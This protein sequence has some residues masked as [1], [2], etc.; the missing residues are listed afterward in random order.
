MNLAKV[1]QHESIYECAS[2][3]K[4]DLRYIVE[5]T[6][7]NIHPQRHYFAD[8]LEFELACHVIS[9]QSLVVIVIFVAHQ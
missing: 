1:L 6:R 8:V 9:Q 4:Y 7:L 3:Y 5:T 2:G